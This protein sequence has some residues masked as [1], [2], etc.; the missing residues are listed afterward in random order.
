MFSSGNDLFMDIAIAIVAGIKKIIPGT[1]DIFELFCC[2]YVFFHP[3]PKYLVAV[4][5]S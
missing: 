2:F 5:F 3:K 1:W 4:N